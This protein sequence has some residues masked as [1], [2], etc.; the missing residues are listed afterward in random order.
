[1]GKIDCNKLVSIIT[2]TY[3]CGKFIGETIESVLCQTYNN[4]EMIIVDDCSTDDTIEIVASFKDPRIKY[5]RLDHNS[6][7]AVAR[8]LALR[9][10]RG[11][12]IAF[13]DSDDLW[14][15]T[16]LERQLSF[17]CR[18]G[19]SFTYHNYTEINEA[20]E[21]L[22]ILVSGKKH[23]RRLD[24]MA[25]CWPGCLS[26]VYDAEKVGLVQIADIKKNNDTALWL[27]VIKETD[28]WLLNENLAKYRR[29]K[30]SV[31]PTGILDKIRHHYPIFRKGEE[32][33]V[34][35]AAFWMLVNI[36]GNSLKKIFF[37]NHNY[38]Y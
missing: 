22:N 35:V 19:Y 24:M 20:G 36:V 9:L 33:S 16:K 30:G 5:H 11:R 29:R 37:V 28:C 7:A 1:M 23:V 3:N 17:M 8:N 13:L 15:P 2:P 21:P 38:H 18:T 34:P 14:L 12:W 10:A 26:V 6:G 27:K 4:W 31:T 32:M 25:C